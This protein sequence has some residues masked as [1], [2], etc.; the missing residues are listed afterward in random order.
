MFHPIYPHFAVSPF[1]VVLWILLA[2]I[3]CYALCYGGNEYF[4]HYR[5]GYT[6]Y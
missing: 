1:G 6:K 3:L 5:P 4:Y 2:T